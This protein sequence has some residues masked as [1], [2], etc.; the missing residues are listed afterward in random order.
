MQEI[1]SAALNS[2]DKEI[3]FELD[4]NA[5]ITYSQL[6]KKVHISK[7]LVR[8]R[9][10]RLEKLGYIKGYYSMVD[11]SALGYIT[12]RIYLK[13]RSITPAVKKTIISYLKKQQTIGAIVYIA[14]KWDLALGVNVKDIRSFHSMW[15][16]LLQRHIEHIANYAISIYSPIYHYAKSY[17]TGKNDSSPI[18]LLGNVSAVSI[19]KTDWKILQILSS[20][21][22]VSLVDVARSLNV[23]A[24][25]VRVRK[26]RLEK[27]DV[28]QGYRAMIDVAKLGYNVFKAEIRLASF[29]YFKKILA[30]CHE[31]P[32]IYQVNNAIGG[33]TLEI[34]FH[35]H[36]LS[37][38]IAILENIE[39]T[40]P[41]SIEQYEYITVLGE[42]KMVYMPSKI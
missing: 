19:D 36:E 23:S 30:F 13:W 37:E 10:E 17:L 11:P 39:E 21:A 1:K 8:Y 24:E 27:Q 28:I 9:V 40:F 14:G 41:G 22:R 26:R 6:A 20:N 18:R 2:K 25:F 42:E 31:H 12:F 38:M 16:N 34:E 33:E 15:N 32:N 7:Q 3:L 5:R 35:V 29:T 4:V